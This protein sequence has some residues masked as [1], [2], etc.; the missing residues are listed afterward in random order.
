MWYSVCEIDLIILFHTC[1]AR[2]SSYTHLIM[3]AVKSHSHLPS[4]LRRQHLS[5]FSVVAQ[6]FRV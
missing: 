5:D 3:I 1:R 2:L 4:Q 6:W